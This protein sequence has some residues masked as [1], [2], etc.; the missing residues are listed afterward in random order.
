MNATPAL[1]IGPALQIEVTAAVVLG[2]RL[3]ALPGVD[4]ERE[5]RAA[6]DR[7][8]A[9]V[10]REL[11]VCARCG[12][13]SDRGRCAGCA[14]SRLERLVRAGPADRLDRSE[15]GDVPAAVSAWEQLRRDLLAALPTRLAGAAMTVLAALDE[16]GL[17]RRQEVAALPAEVLGPVLAA[18]REVGPPGIGAATVEECLLLQ[19]DAA[20][21][22]PADRALARLVLTEHAAELA[23][24]GAAGAARAGGGPR[25]R[26]AELL[27]RLGRL[28]RPFPG[29]A[30]PASMA[31]ADGPPAQPPDLV[32]ERYGGRVQ[33]VVPEAERWAVE[34]DPDYRQAL[35]AARA[36]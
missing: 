30:S 27:A 24:G 16:R 23:G 8:P 29:L 22:A 34:V 25:A 20:P 4:L 13:R 1:E 15:P 19:L 6:A 2:V 10:A 35:A 7:N 5:L 31:A 9:F 26:M 11:P 18:L 36:G 32:F 21:L 12:R 3:L 17:I 33:A 28:L 14:P